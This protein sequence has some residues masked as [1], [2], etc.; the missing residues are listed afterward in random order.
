MDGRQTGNEGKD[1]VA[2]TGVVPREGDRDE[3]K[4]HPSISPAHSRESV[5]HDNDHEE[6]LCVG[7]EPLDVLL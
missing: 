5:P 2:D 6:N 1:E 4:P 7:N 3:L